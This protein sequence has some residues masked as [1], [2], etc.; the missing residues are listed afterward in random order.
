MKLLSLLVGM[1]CTATVAM[2]C[3]ENDSSDIKITEN[4]EVAKFDRINV[5]GPAKVNIVCGQD[6]SVTVTATDKLLNALHTEVRDGELY[7]TFTKKCIKRKNVTVDIC[8]ENIT[9]LLA[10]GACD[11][12]F[13]QYTVLSNL[14]FKASGASNVNFSKLEVKGDLNGRISGASDVD[15]HCT[16]DRAKF[17]VSGASDLDIKNINTSDLDISASGASDVNVSGTTEYVN[18]NASGA[19]DI[20]AKGLS[21]KSSDVRGSGASDINFRR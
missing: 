7:I 16:A 9:D 17:E 20:N 18:L 14:Y 19:S 5:S 6:Q 2:S 8:V 1:L 21:A 4:R 12:N 10:S 11:V 13:P 15:I 3:N